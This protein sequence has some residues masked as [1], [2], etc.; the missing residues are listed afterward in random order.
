LEQ[1]AE[2]QVELG[3]ERL[4]HLQQPALEAHSGLD[5]GDLFHESHS[6]KLPRYHQAGGGQPRPRLRPLRARLRPGLRARL[7]P[8]AVSEA[9]SEVGRAGATG[10]DPRRA[11]S[12]LI[13]G[14]MQTARD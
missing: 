3:R 5:A 12:V 2:R 10:N 6:T 11:R 14:Y 7:R 1:I 9:V 13:N 4:E 8:G